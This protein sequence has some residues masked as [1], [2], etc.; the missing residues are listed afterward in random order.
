MEVSINNSISYQHVIIV[1]HNKVIFM[2]SSCYSWNEWI[3]LPIQFND[4]PR[5]AQ[6]AL[7][8]YDCAGPNKLLPVGGTTV[9]LFSK[10]GVF[11][12]GM[13]DLRVWPNKVADGNFPTTTPG[14]VT[15]EN[16]DD[17]QR[18]A[19]LAKKHRN[20]HIPKVDWLDRLTFRE[21][22]IVNEREKRNSDYLYLIIEF[23]RVI[24]DGS[25]HYVVYFE[26]LV[27]EIHQF[28]AQADIVTVP[29]Q[30][31]LK[32]SNLLIKIIGSNF[33]CH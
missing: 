6:L 30:E 27:D 13:M 11:R 9:S 25:L 1:L 28:K 7:T 2:F 23:P 10:Y 29:D 3:T 8:I 16:K 22:E 24:V 20:G 5:T 12:Q 26:Q 21:I 31:I 15:N 33:T 32:V 17:M 19:K 18:L 14:K 4:L